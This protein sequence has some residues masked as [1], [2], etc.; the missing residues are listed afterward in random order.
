[1]NNFYLDFI[2]NVNFKVHL[3][4]MTFWAMHY[5]DFFTIEISAAEYYVDYK[6]VNLSDKIHL[7]SYSIQNF[8]SS[9]VF[10]CPSWLSGPFTL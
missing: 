1:L 2:T 8:V 7:Q 3:A 5:D 6:N 10:I 9:F 4:F